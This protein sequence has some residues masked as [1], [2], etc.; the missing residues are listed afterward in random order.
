MDSFARQTMGEPESSCHFRRGG[1]YCLLLK[2]P[3]CRRLQGRWQTPKPNLDD[4]VCTARI[5]LRVAITSSLTA[6]TPAPGTSESHD[7]IA[8]ERDFPASALLVDAAH[9]AQGRREDLPCAPRCLTLKLLIT[10][11]RPKEPCTRLPGRGKN[12]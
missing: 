10:G 3:G 8:A 12:A 1:T 6:T 11:T 5:R 9:K 4:D 2:A 7:S